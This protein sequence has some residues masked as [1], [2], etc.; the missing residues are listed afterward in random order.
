MWR[1]SRGGY[2]SHFIGTSDARN[3]I[4]PVH[5]MTRKCLGD[6]NSKIV[7]DRTAE[8]PPIT[9]NIFTQEAERRI[10]EVGAS[11]ATSVMSDMLVHD[12]PQALDRVQVRAIGRDEMQFDSA[13]RLRQP[14]LH[15]LGMMIT[16]VVQKDMDECQHRI[17]RFDRF[18]QFDRRGGVDGFDFDHPGFPGL[19]VNCAMNVDALTPARL[20]DRE[21][22]FGAQQATGRAAWV[23]CTASANSTASLSPKKFMSFS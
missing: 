7:G 18:Q 16:R 12:A 6:M 8:V 4:Y 10:G 19:K 23:G 13:T 20:L 21:L 15:K 14:F 17:K 1:Q 2:A 5:V 11:C 22:C 3:H 9:G